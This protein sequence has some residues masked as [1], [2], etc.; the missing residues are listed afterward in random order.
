MWS[1]SSSSRGHDWIQSEKV[2]YGWMCSKCHG[3]VFD[4][5]VPSENRYIVDDNLNLNTC[6]ELTIRKTMEE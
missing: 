4:E 2:P 1:S 5:G 6:E 3:E